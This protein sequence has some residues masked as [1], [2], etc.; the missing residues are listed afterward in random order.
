AFTGATGQ[1]KGLFEVADKGTLFLDGLGEMPFDCQ[2]KLL[3]SLQFG[4]VSRVGSVAPLQVEARV[5]A[6]TNVDLDE[7]VRAGALRS[8]LFYRLNVLTIR[9]P[10][11]RDRADDACLIAEHAIARYARQFGRPG[12]H[13]SP[14]ALQAIRNHAWPGN[15]RELLNH[16]KRVVLLCE[17]NAIDPEDLG[18]GDGG[19]RARVNAEDG[20][21]NIDFSHGAVTLE[22]LERLLIVRALEHTDGNV[23]SA[24]RLIG[25]N[26]GALRYRIEKLGITFERKVI[27]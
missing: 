18:L 8:D 23:S 9:I 1:K 17:G 16:M 6:A 14:R 25:L 22:D 7:R 3:R 24:A 20:T 4:E 15:V 19:E 12:V 26:R 5:I 11:L 27:T 2:A 13:L 21:L 10:A